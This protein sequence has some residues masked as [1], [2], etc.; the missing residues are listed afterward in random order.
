MPNCMRSQASA[1]YLFV[2]N[3]IG[4]GIGP[5][6]V[7]LFTD[8]VFHDKKAVGDSLLIVSVVAETGAV[9]LLWSGL[10]HYRASLERLQH[11]TAPAL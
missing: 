8:H 3:L 9:L 2:V 11:W 4:L 10:R 1:L 5:T 6:A 7:A